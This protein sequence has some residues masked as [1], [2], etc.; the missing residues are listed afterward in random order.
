MHDRSAIDSKNAQL[1]SSKYGYGTGD[2]EREAN[3]QGS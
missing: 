1:G 2:I 3:I